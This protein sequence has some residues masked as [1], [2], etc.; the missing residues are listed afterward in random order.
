M[1]ATNSE[2]KVIFAIFFAVS[3]SCLTHAQQIIDGRVIDKNT[4]TPVGSASIYST[5]NLYY[6]IS[7]NEGYFRLAIQ[8]DSTMVF[9]SCIGYHSQKLEVSNSEEHVLIRLEPHAG[10][11]L[12]EVTVTSDVNNANSLQTISK[13]DLNLRPF[14]SSQDLLRLVPGLFLGEH[15]G[16]GVAEHIFFRGF[17]ADHGTD[18]N[19]SV[20][21]MPLNLVSQIH[22]QGFSDL[23]FLIPELMASYEFGKGPYY[24]PYGDFATAGYVSFKTPDVVNNSTVKLEG[25]QFNTGRMML[26]LNLLNK[27]ARQKGQNL[28]VAGEAAYTDG[29]FDFAQHFNR[30]NLFGKYYG[31]ISPRSRLTITLSDF[32]SK[33]RSSGEI[34]ERAVAAGLI[35]RFGYIDSLQGGNTSRFNF[36]ARLVTNFSASSYLQNQVYYTHYYFDHHYDDTFF[37]DDSVNGDMMRQREGRDLIGYNGKFT[38][39]SYLQHG[40]ALSSSIGIGWQLNKI[41]N[42]E[43]SHIKGNGDL[44]EYIYLG[45]I[46]E[47][48]TNVYV[49]EILTKNNWLF[50]VG[51]RVDYLHFNYEDKLNPQLPAKGKSIASPKLNIQYTFNSAFQAYFKTGKGFHSNDARVVILNQGYKTLPAAYGADLGINWKP[52]P[53]LYINAALWYLYLQQEFIYDGDEGTIEPGDKTRRQGIDLSA[54][55]QFNHWLFATVDVNLSK[56]RDIEAPKGSN[57][58]PLAV[59]ASS[60][61]GLD[62]KFDNGMNGGI[63]YRYMKNRP[64]NEDNNLIAKGYF[65]TDLTAN[66]TKKKYE[67]GLEI[68]NLFN[69]K[70]REEQFEVESRLRNEPQPVDEVDFTAGTPFFA[71]IKVAAFF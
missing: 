38:H 7:D 2:M 37:A 16:G 60:T 41:Y 54:R 19:V 50:N 43:L 68:Q 67:V 1:R 58:L 33:W 13:I 44:L 25:G 69:T 55:Y 52:L 62:F 65:V 10:I 63:S 32:S 27:K 66:Y 46:D 40:V 36:I 26:L 45:N 17:D 5:D 30:L 12:K 22:G 21:G 53:H 49:D 29:P 64:A 39:K 9:V 3:L 35:D 18:V 4:S 56:A 31:S 51:M 14:N 23:H 47:M 71:K 8:G 34:P 28:Y 42:S 57:Y 61:A 48:V 6:T 59:P 20:D 11:D 24:A 15:H 70:W